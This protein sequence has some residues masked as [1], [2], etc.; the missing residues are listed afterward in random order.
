MA[1]NIV[2]SAVT[3]PSG[4]QSSPLLTTPSLSCFSSTDSDG[5]V[6]Q[7]QLMP[8]KSETKFLCNLWIV[9]FNIINNK[10]LLEVQRHWGIQRNRTV[11]IL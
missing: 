10:I 3:L 5:Y 8:I 2:T 7:P 9:Y 6:S 4:L 11:H 1:F